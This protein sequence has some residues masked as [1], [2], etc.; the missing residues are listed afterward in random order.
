MC[1]PV[2]DDEAVSVVVNQDVR[3]ADVRSFM[4]GA[5]KS[6]LKAAAAIR[7]ANV[8]DAMKSAELH[9]SQ[10]PV[11]GRAAWIKLSEACLQVQDRIS[12]I[13]STRSSDRTNAT[14]PYNISLRDS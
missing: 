13:P 8:K 12:T 6:G 10:G 7:R 3:Y 4:D 9:K 14:L 11:S 1:T 5:A 2:L